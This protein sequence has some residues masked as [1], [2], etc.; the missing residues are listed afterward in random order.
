M[1]FN[2]TKTINFTLTAMAFMCISGCFDYTTSPQ[3][4]Y[5]EYIDSRDGKTYKTVAIGRQ[6]WLAE[7]LNYQTSKSMCYSNND[8]NCGIY[9]RLYTWPE[10]IGISANY[11]NT[12]WNGSDKNIQGVCP[13]GWHIPTE[14]E[15]QQLEI[16][17]GMSATTAATSGLRGGD[18]GLRI[19]GISEWE[20]DYY[21]PTDDFGFHAIASGWIDSLGSSKDERWNTYFWTSTQKTSNQ[22]WCRGLNNNYGTQGIE[23]NAY[24]KAYMFSVRCI[25]N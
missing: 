24:N 7:N 12:S 4:T 9:G 11:S 2:Y 14:S 1:R 25:A 6:I 23:K 19:M 3:P 5:G 10:A 21:K 16:T 17:I 15:W 22:A 8:G 20:T 13:F 18:I